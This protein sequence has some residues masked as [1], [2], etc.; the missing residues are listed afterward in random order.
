M[1]ASVFPDSPIHR[2]GGAFVT[3]YINVPFIRRWCRG[4]LGVGMDVTAE[5][6]GG[7]CSPET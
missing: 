7:W 5:C 4:S 2:A 3:F 6:W 1:F